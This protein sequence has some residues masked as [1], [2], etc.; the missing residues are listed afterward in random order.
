MVTEDDDTRT[1][2]QITG[3]SSI[4]DWAEKNA[5]D[6]HIGKRKQKAGPR[7]NR[8]KKAKTTDEAVLGS[9]KSTLSPEEGRSPLYVD[10]NLSTSSS[11]DDDDGDDEGYQIE[12]SQPPIRFTGV[13]Y[14]QIYLCYFYIPFLTCLTRALLFSGES[15]YTHT[16]QD[17][18]H[19][20]PHSQ[21]ETITDQDSH[22][23]R[24]RGRGRQHYLSPVNNSSSQNTGSSAPYAHGFN[25]YMAPYPS[26]LVQN[27]Q[28]VYEYENPEFYNMSVQQWQTTIAWMGQTWEEY[29]AQLLATQGITILST[30]KLHM[31]HFTWMMPH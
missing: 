27:M 24:G 26:Q 22:T 4:V 25:S 3:T 5:G 17:T 1:L 18:D 2:R 14:R 12:P 8:G 28:W 30:I 15:H 6:T 29:K 16:T 19:G 9:D 11:S 31:A 13:K 10:S 7:K 21:R 20:A 23:G